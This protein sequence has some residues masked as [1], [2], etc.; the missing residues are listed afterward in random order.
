M[1][2]SVVLQSSVGQWREWLITAGLLKSTERAPTGR[3][4]LIPSYMGLVVARLGLLDIKSSLRTR[5]QKKAVRLFGR[6]ASA[7]LAKQAE[8][9][10]A[11]KAG[12]ELTRIHSKR[13]SDGKQ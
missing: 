4:T 12:R 3:R 8:G 11:E 10:G 6:Q 1:E 13:N 2:K 7:V 9:L 5:W